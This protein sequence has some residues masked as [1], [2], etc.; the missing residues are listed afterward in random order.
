MLP[1]E[2]PRP[3]APAT[4]GTKRVAAMFQAFQGA[5]RTVEKPDPEAHRANFLMEFIKLKP[6]VF[7][8]LSDP[9]AA[10]RW[11]KKMKK[12][13]KKLEV[14]QEYRVGFATYLFEGSAEEWWDLHIND[15]N[16]P[17][18]CWDDFET[19][20]RGSYVLEPHRPEMITEFDQLVQDD[21]TVAQYH[22]KFVEL[23][24]Y[25]LSAV[26]DPVSRC[27]KFR[28]GLRRNIRSRLASL[29]NLTDFT[30]IVAAAQRI[31][32]DLIQNNEGH[33]GT[34]G[35]NKKMGKKDQLRGR[36]SLGSSNRGSSA[37]PGSGRYQPYACYICGQTG[38][39]QRSCPDRQQQSSLTFR[40]WGQ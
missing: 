38:H 12:K 10:E 22:D 31:E 27:E 16:A 34:P 29:P 4:F 6:P 11:L 2:N 30:E 3:E 35:G 8:G 21:M 37:S 26:A 1:R 40:S 13:F 5:Q 39:K 25:R 36:S 17:K 20:F 9:V 23:S 18:L 15:Y 19:L 24:R 33:K 32:A 14:P 7:R 28:A